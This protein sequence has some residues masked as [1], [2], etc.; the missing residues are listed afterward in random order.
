VN[1]WRST[2]L[3]VAKQEMMHLAINCDLVTS[4]GAR[5][6]A[7]PSGSPACP[8]PPTTTTSWSKRGPSVLGAAA[9]DDRTAAEALVDL[10][11]CLMW[12][13]RGAPN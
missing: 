12:E 13:R 1:R 4:L 11:D 3:L 2:I 6:S 9:E 10:E 8:H 5:P 7:R